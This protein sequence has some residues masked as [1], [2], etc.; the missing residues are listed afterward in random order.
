MERSDP[1]HI[2]SSTAIVATAITL[3]LL[4]LGTVT[5]VASGPPTPAL[6]DVPG[7]GQGPDAAERDDA[8]AYYEAYRRSQIISDCMSKAGFEHEP[9]ADFPEQ[10]VLH[11]ADTLGVEVTPI[12]ASDPNV[13]NRRYESSLSGSERDRYLRTLLGESSETVDQVRSTGELPAGHDGD[14]GHGGCTGEA[15]DQVGTIWGL[16]RSLAD[17]RMALLERARNTDAFR[18][19]AS[20]YSQCVHDATGI[21]VTGPSDVEERQVVEYDTQLAAAAASCE[22]HWAAAN[23]AGQEAVAGDFRDEHAAAI[24]AQQN[25]YKGMMHRV[26]ADG[27]F[28]QFLEQTAER[29]EAADSAQ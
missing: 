7:L 5:A 4:G 10:A 6:D 1:K 29:I 27:D 26:R 22:Q 3:T 20:Q 2:S 12:P 13:T 18:T 11:V 16:R 28:M 8:I 17:A 25:R 23:R 9:E 19:H 24:E 15:I 14:F 21:E